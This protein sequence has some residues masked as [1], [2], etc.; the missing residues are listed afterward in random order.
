MTC[1]NP[2][3]YANTQLTPEANGFNHFFGFYQGAIDYVT[4][5]YNDIEDGAEAVFDFFEDEEACY[6]V[7]DSEENTMDLY[8]TKIREYLDTE[9]QKVESATMNNEV[10]SPFF[11]MATL[12]SMHAPFPVLRDYEDECK[13]RV[14]VSAHSQSDEYK[15][16]RQLYCELTL[17]TDRVV[18]EIIDGLNVSISF[19]D[20]F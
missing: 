19:S 12:Q 6:F 15:E 3:G 2:K 5:V 4:K 17:I 14:S 16:W 9:G 18:G 8:S 7:I 1:P 13:E 20:S 11:M 10:A